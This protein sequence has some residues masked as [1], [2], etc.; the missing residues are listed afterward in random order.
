MQDGMHRI[1]V[2]SAAKLK[3]TII[4]EGQRV[5]LDGRHATPL[6]GDLA[7][8]AH[9]NQ[10]VR[11]LQQLAGSLDRHVVQF[12]VVDVDDNVPFLEVEPRGH[13]A[14]R[15]AVYPDLR[16]VRIAT[17]T[18]ADPED[19]QRARQV[20]HMFIISKGTPKT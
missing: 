2:A 6:A 1:C 14:G 9:S 5:E 10:A 15:D 8:E 18:A 17:N 13:R 16:S 3:R 20:M 19:M 4:C 11:L 7:G 12:S